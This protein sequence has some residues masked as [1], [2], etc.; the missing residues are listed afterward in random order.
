MRQ[1]LEVRN[2]SVSFPSPQGSI[3]IIQ[4]LS[5]C[6][7][8]GEKLGIV[9]ES[10]SGKSMLL[11]TILQL[12]SSRN[13]PLVTGEV[14]YLGKNLLSYSE[15][16]MQNIR[17]KEISMVFQD[18]M[19]S[20]NPTKKIGIQIM[21]GYLKHHSDKKKQDAKE[22]AL[23]ILSL[24]GI[25]NP[26]LRF[27]MYPHN[28]SGGLRQRVMI[29]I[30]LSCDPKLLLADEPTTALDALTQMQVLSLLKELQEKKKIAI[31]LVT[32]DL[33]AVSSFCNRV[34]VMHKGQIV[35]QANVSTLFTNPKH[36]YTK[37]LLESAAL[38]SFGEACP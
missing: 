36:P 17:G 15:K 2:L 33:G 31:I 7:A 6:I 14:L 4:N 27:S 38:S 22:Y 13:P 8:E 32:H 9:G 30:A 29:A 23:E 20:L 35:E 34:L 21:E 25:E 5:F 12:F 18:P 19:S 26:K 1:I 24:V 37:M 11:K 10:G 3:P 16:E 28:L